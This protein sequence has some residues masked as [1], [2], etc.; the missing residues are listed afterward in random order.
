[1]KHLCLPFS[2]ES[3]LKYLNSLNKTVQQLSPIAKYMPKFLL[4]DL[5]A[6]V[7]VYIQLY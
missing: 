6:L 7:I 5:S 3:H 4:P 2:W 1:M